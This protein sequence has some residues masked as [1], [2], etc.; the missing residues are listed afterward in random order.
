VKDYR[1]RGVATLFGQVTLRLPRFRC[2]ACGGIEAGIG[3]PSHCQSTPELDQLQAHLSALMTYRIVLRRRNI[4]RLSI[5]GRVADEQQQ[6][7]I[8]QGQTQIG[9][10][11]ET[12]VPVLRSQPSG[13]D[14]LREG[15]S[16]ATARPRCSSRMMEDE[17]CN[18]RSSPAARS[19]KQEPCGGPS[20][21]PDTHLAG[22]RRTPH[23]VACRQLHRSLTGSIWD[24]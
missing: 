2:A 6:L 17:S 9:D 12:Q 11:A 18:T 7:R 4:A 20:R 10:I 8:G 23:R 21:A 5:F 24:G 13:D 3:W 16:A 15:R 19:R 1:E 22:S 14:P